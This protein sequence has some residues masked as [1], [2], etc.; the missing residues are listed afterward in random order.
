MLYSREFY[1]SV[2]HDENRA[3]DGLNLRERFADE[4]GYDYDFLDGPGS[5]ECTILEMM[6]AL[7]SRCENEIMYN[8]DEGD[9]TWVWFWGMIENLGL[10]GMD[11]AHFNPWYVNRI[12]DIFLNREYEKDG[13]D[14]KSTRLNSSH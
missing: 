4:F 13:K 14:R 2:D 11:D 1:W 3:E 9:R 8:P 10:T 5:S 12:L 7:A 6:V